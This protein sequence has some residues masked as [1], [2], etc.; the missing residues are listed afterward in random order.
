MSPRVV[1]FQIVLYKPYTKARDRQAVILKGKDFVFTPKLR[2]ACVTM[3]WRVI[4]LP[5]KYNSSRL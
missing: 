2:L 5:L 1:S 4:E 3:A